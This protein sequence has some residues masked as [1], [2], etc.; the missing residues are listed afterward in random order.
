VKIPFVVAGIGAS[1][2]QQSPIVGN[3]TQQGIAAK[4]AISTAENGDF[5]NLWL[6][7]PLVNLQFSIWK[8][9]LSY[10]FIQL[11]ISMCHVQ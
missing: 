7:Y 2:N 8:I 1:H 6:F 5:S 9:S 4:T 3:N 11:Y 10:Y